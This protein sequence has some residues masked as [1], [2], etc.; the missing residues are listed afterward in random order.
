MK[1]TMVLVAMALVLASCAT[2]IEKWTPLPFDEA[3]YGALQ[4]VGTG[5]VRGSVFAKTV[6]GDLKLGAG[7]FVRLYPVTKYTQQRYRENWLAG[8]PATHSEDPRYI[9]YVREKTVG[10]DGKFEFRDV[11]PGDYYAQSN[12]T[13]NVVRPTSLGPINESQ[14]GLVIKRI[15]VTNGQVTDVALA[16]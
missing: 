4:T 9:K 1:R 5:I 6:G 8:K 2:P 3:E 12:V 11:P 16:Y 13:W 10:V 15:T 14:G 7:E